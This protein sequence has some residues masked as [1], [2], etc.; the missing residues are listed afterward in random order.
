M[1]LNFEKST[2]PVYGLMP[3]SCMVLHMGILEM[4][5]GCMVSFEPKN[6]NRLNNMALK[7]IM[8]FIIDAMNLM[9]E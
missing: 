2:L 1:D 9:K 3:S 4:A 7:E 6:A 5:F 8:S